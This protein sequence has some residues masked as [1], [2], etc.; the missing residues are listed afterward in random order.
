M[1]ASGFNLQSQILKVGH[2]GSSYSTSQAFLSGVQATY[3]V[4]CAGLGNQ[5]GHPT[6]QTLDRLSS[7]NIATYGTYKDGTIIFSL[8]SAVAQDSGTPVNGIISAN[9]IW[10]KSSSP[11][12][13]TGNVLVDVGVTL[14]IEPGVTVNFNGYFMNVGGT[15]SARGTE[16]E[17]II[18][19]GSGITYS[20]EWKGRI[21]FLSTSTNSIIENAEITSNPNTILGIYS[22]P[23]ISQTTVGGTTGTAISIIDGSP[24]IIENIISNNGA[25]GIK[26]NAASYVCSAKISNNVITNN[27]AAGISIYH[28]AVLIQK[29]NITNNYAGIY[30][31][32]WWVP[33]TQPILLKT[34]LQIITL[35]F[36]A[37]SLLTAALMLLVK[38]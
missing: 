25:D 37:I 15:L 16:N 19:K 23:K 12:N 9:T 2:H 11:H 3:A 18:M 8:N 35:A 7:N 1:L 36:N 20:G 32:E 30:N 28:G 17:K 31:E 4:I 21:V 29:N 34:L 26:V 38:M 27:T 10:T 13:F 33:M 6:Q 24:I 5:F 22:S 14:T